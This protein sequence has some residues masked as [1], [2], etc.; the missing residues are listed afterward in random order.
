MQVPIRK[1]QSGDTTHFVVPA[2]AI[3]ITG[4]EK[5]LIPNPA[6]NEVCTFATL[7]EAKAAIERAGFDAIYDGITTVNLGHRGR[8]PLN[9]I[10]PPRLSATLNEQVKQKLLGLLTDREPP[11]AIAAIQALASWQYAPAIEPLCKQLGHSD[12]GVRKEVA[13]ALAKLSPHSLPALKEAYRLATGSIEGNAPYIRAAVL[14]SFQLMLQDN[15]LDS[16]ELLP[17]VL[18]GLTDDHW[19]VRSQAANTAAQ[20]TLH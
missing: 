10:R 5:K 8:S 13:N 12:P 7:D 18:Q 15:A 17:V 1:Q 6:G 19:M 4:G 14:F 11:V 9:P 20:L 16:V 2:V 3:A